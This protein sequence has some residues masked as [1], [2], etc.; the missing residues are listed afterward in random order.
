M[1][2]PVHPDRTLEQ[3]APVGQPGER[4]R[5]RALRDCIVAMSACPQDITPI[6]GG[7]RTPQDGHFRVVPAETAG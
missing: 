2:I 4:V 6:N 5:L 7:D 3:G 1:N